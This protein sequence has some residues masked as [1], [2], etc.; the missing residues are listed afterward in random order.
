[1]KE[2]HAYNSDVGLEN[3]ILK[4]HPITSNIPPSPPLDE[5]LRG[6]LEENNKYVQIPDG[7]L[8]LK[9]I[10]YHGFKV[11]VFLKIE[12][13]TQCKAVRVKINICEFKELSITMLKQL[14]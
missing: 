13:S 1:M 5:F 8:L 6:V 9:R 7:K 2:F 10:E 11:K 3:R 12:E 4:W 14:S